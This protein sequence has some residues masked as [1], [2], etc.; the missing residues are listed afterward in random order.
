MIEPIGID[1][2]EKFGGQAVKPGRLTIWPAGIMSQEAVLD[3]QSKKVYPDSP[4]DVSPD[5]NCKYCYG[6]SHEGRDVLTG[7]LRVCR[8]VLKKIHKLRLEGKLYVHSP[9]VA[10]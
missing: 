10:K 1:I 6:R 4:I 8:C 9:R 5:P 3:E 7:K 2:C